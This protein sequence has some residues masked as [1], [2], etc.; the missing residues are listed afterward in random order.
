MATGDILSDGSV[1]GK[2]FSGP[3]Y[4]GEHPRPQEGDTYKS[5]RE[6]VDKAKEEGFDLG[7]LSWGDWQTYCMGS[8]NYEGVD[9]N[10]T[11]W[12]NG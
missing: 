12:G 9:A 2:T 11:I 10:E 6:R 5:Y 7:D 1:E 4:T 8:G 3:K